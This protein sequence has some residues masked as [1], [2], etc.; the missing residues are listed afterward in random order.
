M[1]QDVV[2]QDKFAILGHFCENVLHEWLKFGMLMFCGFF[3]NKLRFGHG[4]LIFLILAAFWFSETGHSQK[5]AWKEWP[6]IW[7]AYGIID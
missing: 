1:L 4:L 2:K 3:Q 5:N 7:P 6:E